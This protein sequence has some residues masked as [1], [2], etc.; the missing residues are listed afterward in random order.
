MTAASK[1]ATVPERRFALDAVAD[2]IQRFP[3]G[4]EAKR[5]SDELSRYMVGS[6]ELPLTTSFIPSR[7]AMLT[8]RFAARY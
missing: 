7:R 5:L 4:G 2:L 1:A 3:I 8:L 6:A